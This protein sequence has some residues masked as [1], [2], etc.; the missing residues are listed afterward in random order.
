MQDEAPAAAAS[1][2][3]AAPPRVH[4]AAGEQDD[5]QQLRAM[6]PAS[7]ARSRHWMHS[8][9]AGRLPETFGPS[10]AAAKLAAGG[11]TRG[12]KADGFA[13]RGSVRTMLHAASLAKSRQPDTPAS[14]AAPDAAARTPPAVVNNA[15]IAAPAVAPVTYSALGSLTAPAARRA[16]IPSASPPTSASASGAA[17]AAAPGAGAGAA[18]AATRSAAP[19]MGAPSG[20]D[21]AAGARGSS[22]VPAAVRAAR[23]AAAAAVA[24]VPAASAV[25]SAHRSAPAPRAGDAD[26]EPMSVSLPEL[27]KFLSGTQAADSQSLGSAASEAPARRT[28]KLRPSK[29][30]VA[31]EE[32]RDMASGADSAA[33]ARGSFHA[34]FH[35]SSA[36]P[37]EQEP[38]RRNKRLPHTP[39]HRLD[40]LGP[41]DV[42]RRTTWT[43]GASGSFTRRRGSSHHSRT[44][45]RHSADAGPGRRKPV[46]L[47]GAPPAEPGAASAAG[48]GARGAEWEGGAQRR[49]R[50]R[51]FSRGKWGGVDELA[52]KLRRRGRAGMNAQP[53][54][55]ES[56]V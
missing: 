27:P 17:K 6:S 4:A 14:A 29:Q 31:K 26:E 46:W 43:K 15:S 20:T 41:H 55:M 32:V 54:W 11:G 2:I 22:R 52:A 56:S 7:R 16:A 37:A 33:A 25:G 23:A 35:A 48:A 30:Q 21:K 51:L 3:A 1:E 40:N 38:H 50:P 12:R 18:A 34:P 24:G 47:A 44:A 19:R 53:S 49:P 42:H 28:A 13:R 45:T 8:K 39:R 36:A 9:S 10:G 5:E